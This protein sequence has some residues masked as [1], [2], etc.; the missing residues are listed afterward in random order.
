MSRVEVTPGTCQGE[1]SADVAVAIVW[2]VMAKMQQR[3]G[4]VLGWPGS[5]GMLP[6]ESPRVESGEGTVHSALVPEAGRHSLDKPGHWGLK[7]VGSRAVRVST[8]RPPRY[9]T[10]STPKQH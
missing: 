2:H 7:S 8:A 1:I 5:P 10:T 6:Q 9:W 3:L 4:S